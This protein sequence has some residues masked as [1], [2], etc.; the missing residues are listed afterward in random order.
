MVLSTGAP[1]TDTAV[2]ALLGGSGFGSPG[3]AV[4]DTLSWDGA[5]NVP[6]MA[7]LAVTQWRAVIT[8]ETPPTLALDENRQ[9]PWHVAQRL[10]AARIS[11]DPISVFVPLV[12]E[13]GPGGHKSA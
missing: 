5:S 1:M 10:E 12:A 11:D 4:G 3:F 8:W 2:I 13:V 6:L 9:G 7:P